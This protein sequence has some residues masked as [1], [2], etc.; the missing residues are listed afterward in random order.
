M[1]FYEL[2]D[3]ERIELTR[4]AMTERRTV[5][6][7]W[8]ALEQTEAAPWSERAAA[9]AE[10]LSGCASV[11][12]LGCGTMTLKRHLAPGTRY[13]P[14]DVVARDADT[15]VVDL[16]REPLPALAVEGTA[17]LGLLEYLFDVPA[18]FRQLSGVVVTSYNPVDLGH[19]GPDEQADRRRHAWVND[20]STGQL[21]ALFGEAGWSVADRR[22]LG[23]QRIWKLLR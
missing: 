2:S 7:R 4:R 8:S 12:D 14:V 9:A 22:T 18:L 11:A 10:F 19:A 23:G 3:E 15:M 16:N 20:Y 6:E 21:E 5:I 13:V 17:A 1:G